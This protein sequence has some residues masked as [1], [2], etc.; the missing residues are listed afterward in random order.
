MQKTSPGRQKDVSPHG[1]VVIHN[2]FLPHIGN[3]WLFVLTANRWMDRLTKRWTDR[4]SKG[5]TVGCTVPQFLGK[6]QEYGV[7]IT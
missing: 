6:S 2:V 7:I 3:F 4:Q 1:L 5:R